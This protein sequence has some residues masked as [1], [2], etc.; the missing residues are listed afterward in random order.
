MCMTSLKGNRT[1]LLPTIIKEE[2]NATLPDRK[3]S[4]Q[5]HGDKII[6]KFNK[7]SSKSKNTSKAE[8]K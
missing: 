3:K 5:K 1:P 6:K 7:E 2:A 4:V 8:M